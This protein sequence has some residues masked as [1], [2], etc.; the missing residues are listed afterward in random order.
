M[1]EE[2][3][4]AAEHLRDEAEVSALWFKGHGFEICYS[5]I[6]VT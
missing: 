6:T 2:E 3:K 5:F 4:E 1:A